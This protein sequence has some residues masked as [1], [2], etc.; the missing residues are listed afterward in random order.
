MYFIICFTLVILQWVIFLKIIDEKLSIGTV[1]VRII[2]RR[3]CQD[4]INAFK[5]ANYGINAVDAD[6]NKV[7][8]KLFILL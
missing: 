8:G 3:E 7:K 5:K 2:N 1:G 6:G 4:L